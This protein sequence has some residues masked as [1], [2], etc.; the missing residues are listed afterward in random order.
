MPAMLWHFDKLSGGLLSGLLRFPDLLVVLKRIPDRLL[1]L[2]ATLQ[3]DLG[4]P[5]ADIVL[6]L[7]V[8][9][10]HRVNGGLKHPPSI[11]G[12]RPGQDNRVDMVCFFVEI[13]PR[14]HAIRAEMLQQPGLRQFLELFLPRGA[15]LP[16]ELGEIGVEPFPLDRQDDLAERPMP[17]CPPR[18]PRPLGKAPFQLRGPAP[19][20][21]LL[22]FHGKV[23]RPHLP[24]LAERLLCPCRAAQK[25]PVQARPRAIDMAKIAAL[26]Q[27]MA[28]ETAKFRWPQPLHPHDD[29]VLALLIRHLLSSCRGGREVGSGGWGRKRSAPEK[30]RVNR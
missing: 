28:F 29:Q 1:A 15:S 10:D 23:L 3:A 25:A 26:A 22:E 24:N 6:R 13:R 5:G 21:E 27:A 19:I 18:I 16:E 30:M 9:A 4:E 7:L 2:L 12:G 8:A 17:C 20:P 14:M 11:L